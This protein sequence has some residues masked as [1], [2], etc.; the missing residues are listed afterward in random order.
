MIILL[1]TYREQRWFRNDTGTFFPVRLAIFHS[2]SVWEITSFHLWQVFSACS[3][4]LRL[5]FWKIWVK[6]SFGRFSRV[7]LETE[8]QTLRGCFTFLLSGGGLDFDFL[9]RLGFIV[10]NFVQIIFQGQDFRIFGGSSSFYPFI[11]GTF[12]LFTCYLPTVFNRIVRTKQS[13]TIFKTIIVSVQFLK[14]LFSFPSKFNMM[15]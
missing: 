2:F 9:A 8:V 14:P 12:Y 4:S 11:I 15:I 7:S 6:I 10:S 13:V 3:N 1:S 5:K